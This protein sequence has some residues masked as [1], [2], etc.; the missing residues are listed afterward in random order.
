[1]FPAQPQSNPNAGVGESAAKPLI[2]TV[3]QSG[4]SSN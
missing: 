2:H 4:N 3:D 1:M